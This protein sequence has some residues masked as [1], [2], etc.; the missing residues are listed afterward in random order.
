MI[1]ATAPT[2]VGTG[3][4][5][6]VSFGSGTAT[7]VGPAVDDFVGEVGACFGA[8]AQLRAIDVFGNLGPVGKVSITPTA[9]NRFRGG[10]P[11]IDYFLA[12]GALHALIRPGGPLQLQWSAINADS[13]VIR[14]V[15][16][17]PPQLPAIP[18]GD[19]PP[20]G[21]LLFA[22]VAGG[23]WTGSYELVA[24]NGC[25]QVTQSVEIEMRTRKALALAGGGA[26]G[27]FEVGAAR[28]LYDVFGYRPDLVTGASVGALNAAKLAEGPAALPQLEQLWK[29]MTGPQDLFFVRAQ[30][31]T[32]LT[33]MGPDIRNMLNLTPL[34]DLLGWSPA[35]VN[36]DILNLNIA[37][38]AASW[39]NSGVGSA[40][41]VG[42][43]FTVSDILF[44]GIGLGLTI[45]KIVTAIQQLLLQPSLLL[46]DPVRD[47]IDNKVSP[48]AVRN[49]GVRLRIVVN[50]LRTGK[51]RY[52]D[53]NG[54]FV[55]GGPAPG[56]ANV[57]AASASIP[58]VYPPVRLPDGED[59][60]DGGVLENAPIEAAVR[61]GADEVIAVLPSPAA[62]AS[63]STAPTTLLPITA[64]SLDLLLDGSSRR[65]VEPFRGW[66]VPVTVIAPRFELYNLLAV[67]PGLIRINMDYGYM[68]G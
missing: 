38:R 20:H 33:Q 21:E 43:I 30:I 27:S 23:T 31:N 48:T 41:G 50:G 66:G 52:V 61:A 32:I 24:A 6:F 53:E 22:S 62:L 10:P 49:S 5:G 45:G 12:N 28:C 4:V 47:K 29:D 46:F 63:P 40:A 19:Q 64:R 42:T 14:P 18:P 54:A 13:V 37:A 67:D 58:I 65:Q 44:S 56:L 36:L 34:E 9:T 7:P 35:P 1:T 39:A 15:G 26:K 25:G 59:Y 55:D 3:P 11:K 68:R 2:G 16:T 60:V 51:V 8:G 57:L 17:A